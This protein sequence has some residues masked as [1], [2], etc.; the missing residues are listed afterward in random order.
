M[1]EREK[2][3]I[4]QLSDT[5]QNLDRENQKYVLGIAEGMAMAKKKEDREADAVCAS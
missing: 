3:I 5:F 1:S 4:K 2:S